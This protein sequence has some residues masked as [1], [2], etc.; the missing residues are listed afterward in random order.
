MKKLP[1]CS[2]NAHLTIQAVGY[3]VLVRSASPVE[4]DL[5]A[6]ELEVHLSFPRRT[7]EPSPMRLVHHRHDPTPTTDR[8]V[9]MPVVLSTSSRWRGADT[10]SWVT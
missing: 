8:L 10:S 3:A 9:A 4:Q 6:L 5:L 1:L 2:P 7:G